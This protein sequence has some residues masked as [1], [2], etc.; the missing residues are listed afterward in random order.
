VPEQL[1]AQVTPRSTWLDILAVLALLAAAAALFASTLHI[2]DLTHRDEAR[3]ALTARTMYEQG[4]YIIPRTGP[5]LY[6]DK[7]PLLFWLMGLSARLSGGFSDVAVKLPS[8]AAGVLAVVALYLIGRLFFSTVTSLLAG[9]VTATSALFLQTSQQALT[10]PVLICFQSW[11]LYCFIRGEYAPG[12]ARGWYAGFYLLAALATLTKGP[13]GL[14]VPAAVL[15]VWVLSKRGFRDLGRVG[16]HWG[17]PLYLAVLAAWVVPA[18]VMQGGDYVWGFITQIRNRAQ[19]A[20]YS[21]QEPWHFYLWTLFLFAW[22]WAFYL[23]EA[24]VRLG[25]TWKRLGGQVEA[26]RLRQ[27]M[28]LVLIWFLVVMAGWSVAS[29]KRGRYILFA[30]PAAA[31]AIAWL[32]SAILQGRARWS[33]ATTVAT[34]LCALTAFA[35]A[36][37]GFAVAIPKTRSW[38][39]ALLPID[40][41]VPPADRVA[42]LAGWGWLFAG[43]ALSLL[44]V[45]A[46]ILWALRKRPP[47]VYWG[48]VAL[49]LVVQLHAGLWLTSML[50]LHRSMRPVAELCLQ[51]RSAHPGAQVDTHKLFWTALCWYAGSTE[52]GDIKRSKDVLEALQSE[53]P[54]FVLM[55]SSRFDELGRK[56]PELRRYLLEERKAGIRPITILRSRAPEQALSPRPQPAP[57]PHPSAESPPESGHGP[58][59]SAG[60]TPPADSGSPTTSGSADPPE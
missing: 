50:N 59:E 46:A 2:R 41:A 18:A 1:Q 55:E 30:Y 48:V 15:A 21:A 11:A 33:P 17:L 16:L 22:P 8:I 51:L 34:V 6:R 43:M 54:A 24:L 19:G 25:L 13:I 10:D 57:P 5:E 42:A 39:M 4:S 20:Q 44:A 47:W 60:T 45:G 49:P 52:F 40:S 23:P 7:P 27:G 29:A 56:L 12:R 31:L 9:L 28:L 3:F 26:R 36:V 53:K 14:L 35:T 32:W 58:P 38:V 37:V